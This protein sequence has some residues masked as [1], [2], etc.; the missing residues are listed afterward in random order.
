M[1]SIDAADA[2]RLDSRL[3]ASSATPP[4]W[5]ARTCEVRP[6]SQKSGQVRTPDLRASSASSS[7]SAAATTRSAVSPNFS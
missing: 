3:A 7:D 5:T 4:P 2:E 6:K 1:T